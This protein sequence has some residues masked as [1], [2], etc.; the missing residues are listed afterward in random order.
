MALP[1]QN[2]DEKGKELFKNLPTTDQLAKYFRAGCRTT[3]SMDSLTFTPYVDLYEFIKST[4]ASPK[5][6][7]YSWMLPELLSHYHQCKEKYWNGYRKVGRKGT[8]IDADRLLQKIR[9]LCDCFISSGLWSSGLSTEEKSLIV[10]DLLNSDVSSAILRSELA[11]WVDYILRQETLPKSCQNELMNT[12]GLE[13]VAR[14]LRE[15]WSSSSIFTR[16]TESTMESAINDETTLD[17]ECVV[18]LEV[19]VKSKLIPCA[20]QI[21]CQNCTIR[22]INHPCPYCDQTIIG[23]II[24]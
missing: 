5:M 2:V 3:K 19:S 7:N 17:D 11:G 16:Q 9:G 23:H 22:L 20:H 21:T 6:V 15:R 4:K 8:P 14:Q 1:P 18:C 10:N 13:T 24:L 12:Q